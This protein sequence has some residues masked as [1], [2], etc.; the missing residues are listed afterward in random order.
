MEVEVSDHFNFARPHIVPARYQ[1][2]IARQLYTGKLRTIRIFER[3]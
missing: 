2:L 1:K 3:S